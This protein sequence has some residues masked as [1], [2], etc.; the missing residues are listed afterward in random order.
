MSTRRLRA[1]PLHPDESAV[2]GTSSAPPENEAPT[3]HPRRI[4]HVG[5]ALNPAGM[6]ALVLGAYRRI[7]RQRVQFDFAVPETAHGALRDEVQIRQML[8]TPCTVRSAPLRSI[9][10]ARAAVK[11]SR[12]ER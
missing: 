9:N 6:E 10:H 1:A 3:G 8:M 11:F 12:F 4:L 7:D 5:L 2:I